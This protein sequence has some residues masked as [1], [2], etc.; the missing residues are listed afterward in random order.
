MTRFPSL[1]KHLR[2]QWA[3]LLLFAA[4]VT[5][6]FVHREGDHLHVGLPYVYLGDEVH[7]LVALNS[8]LWDGD[9]EL[10]NNYARASLGHVD[11]GIH[12]AG[13][14]LDHHTYLRSFTGTVHQQKGLFG[15]FEDKADAD[16]AG[17]PRP[18]A[19]RV[20]KGGLLPEEYSWHPS[21]P[22]YLLAPFLS[23]LPRTA[24]EPVTIGLIALLTFLAALRFR[25]LCS[26]FVPSPLYADLSMLAVFIGT[27][28]LFYSRAFFPESFF[29]ILVVLAC[30]SCVVRRHWLQPG[31]YLMLAAALK[32]PAALLAVPVILLVASIDLRKALAIFSLVCGGVWFSFF[33]LRGLKGVM[34]AGTVV[35]PERLIELSSLA[36]MPSANLFH[37]R[38]GLFMFAPVLVLSLVGWLPLSR[39]FPKEAG[40]ILAGVILNFAFLCLIS[41]YGSSYAGRYQVP[42]VPLLGIGF[43]GLWF[44][45][46]RV[47]QVLLAAFTVLLLVSAA[48]NIPGTLGGT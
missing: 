16:S 23:V 33:E 4:L 24:V 13:Q 2:A 30:H 6:V 21:Y 11:S 39:R 44:F 7:Y 29:V 10:G 19:K 15:A 40:A 35:D 42:F 25:E 41:F 34:Q 14:M 48:I 36:Y 37:P 12:R 1:L 22:L 5:I 45:P 27:P 32:P 18:R 47:R 43:V 26:V 9:V 28:V 31:L 20:P 3:A 46:L 8:V 17:R 38:Y